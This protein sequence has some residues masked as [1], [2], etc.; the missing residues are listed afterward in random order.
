MVATTCQYP[1]HCKKVRGLELPVKGT[2]T[3][4]RE[5][6]ALNIEIPL[7]DRDWDIMADATGGRISEGPKLAE[8]ESDGVEIDPPAPKRSDDARGNESMGLEKQP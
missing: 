7:L 4:G 6:P 3:L 2:L 8:G 1:I 5:S